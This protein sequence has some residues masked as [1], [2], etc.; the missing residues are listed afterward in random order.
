MSQVYFTA[1]FA[2]WGKGSREGYSIYYYARAGAHA[3]GPCEKDPERWKFLPDGTKN[4]L[5][6][7]YSLSDDTKKIRKYSP[8]K[9]KNVRSDG[10]FIPENVDFSFENIQEKH[11]KYGNE[12]KKF[13]SLAW[14]KQQI[15]S[16]ADGKIQKCTGKE[17][18]KFIESYEKS[19]KNIRPIG[20]N[21]VID[22]RSG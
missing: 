18:E 2:E 7:W 3:S 5:E 15:F 9:G 10:K 1:D 21:S 11:T 6:G 17:A 16:Q 4:I 20:I 22:G 19:M 12:M 14:K 8:R 13:L